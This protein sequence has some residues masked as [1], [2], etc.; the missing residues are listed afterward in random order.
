MIHGTRPRPILTCR[1]CGA[2]MHAKTSSTGLR[3]FAH[4]R[5]ASGCP[6]VGETAEHLQLKQT[7]A[8]LIRTLGCEAQLEATPTA[9]DAGGWRAD[10]LATSPSGVRL[11]VEV[12]LAA[13]TIEEGAR[14]TE[15]YSDDRIASLWVSP[16]H[17]RWLSAIPS[18]HL[19]L[20]SNGLVA[21]RGLARFREG[22]WVSADVVPLE[23]VVEGMLRSAIVAVPGGYFHEEVEGRSFWTE[24]STLLAS[25]ADQELHRR[26]EEEERRRREDAIRSREAH[27]VNRAALVERQGRV[28]QSALHAL[29]EQEIRPS[30][31]WLGIPSTPWDGTFPAPLQF[32]T[33]NDKTAQGAAIWVVRNT[34]L[35][36]WAVVC[37]VASRAT[38]G[39]GESWLR[40][41]VRVFVETEGERVRVARALCWPQSAVTLLQ[42]PGAGIGR[43]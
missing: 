42:T 24:E 25:R 29:L 9:D 36:L 38:P 18:C 21:D 22:R 1:D 23:K 15:R 27:Q 30:Q 5:A 16:R 26:H 34:S 11:A 4:D 35:E 17:P 7:L 14:R 33:G 20:T 39:L 10:V 19:T 28:L 12:Q 41:N 37:P 8:E 13:M 40:R 6:S 2:R 32:A 3:F 43:A 31:V